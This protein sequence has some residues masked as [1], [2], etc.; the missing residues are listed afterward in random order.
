MTQIEAA[1]TAGKLDANEANVSAKAATL[2]AV[3][4]RP[5]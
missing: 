2:Y 5:L 4:V 1:M 3:K